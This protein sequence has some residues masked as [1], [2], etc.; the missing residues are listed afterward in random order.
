VSLELGFDLDYLIFR[1]LILYLAKLTAITVVSNITLDNV[2]VLKLSDGYELWSQKISVI[3]EGMGLQKIV[4]I[5][6]DPSPLEMGEDFITF[7]LAQGQELLVISQVMCNDI[8]REI[9]KLKTLHE[10][11]IYLR[12]SHQKQSTL[13]YFFAL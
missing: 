11:W 1:Q 10:F 12:M 13:S 5:S 4:V 6:I 3:F 7:Q 9:T 2:E 8:L